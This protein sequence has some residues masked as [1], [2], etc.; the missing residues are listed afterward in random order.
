MPVNYACQH[1]TKQKTVTS[2]FK[3]HLRCEVINQLMSL[4]P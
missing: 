3:E 2:V 1:Y 4:A